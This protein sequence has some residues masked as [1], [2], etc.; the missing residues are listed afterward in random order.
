MDVKIN[1][2]MEPR[3]AEEV[4]SVQVRGENSVD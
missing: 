3:T 1:E 2:D 4:D